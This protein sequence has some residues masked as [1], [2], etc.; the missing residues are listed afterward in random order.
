MSIVLIITALL[1]TAD[2]AASTAAPTDKSRQEEVAQIAPAKA[3]RLTLRVGDK[4]PVEAKLHAEP[5]LRWSNPT[6]GSVYGEVFLWTADRRPAAIAS[7]YRWYDP[8]KDSSVEFVSIA[9]RGVA[10]TEEG[11]THWQTKIPGL[12][13]AD[14]PSAR[15]PAQSGR[16]RL[17]QMRSLAR[18]FS[19][20]LTDKRSGDVVVRKLRLLDQPVYRYDN[21][22]ES[23]LDGGLFAF[24]EGTDPEAWLLLE[25]VA[26]EGGRRW[27]FALARMNIDELRVRRGDAIVKEWPGLRDAWSDRTAP[28]IMFNF[29]PDTLPLAKE[30]RP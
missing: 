2:P 7:I 21:S 5:L 26:G 12:H 24:V 30:P 6:A 23:V 20:E 19:T 4:D 28:Y 27:R 18:E 8:Y 3:K 15:A 17:G 29:D 13:F 14:L 11:V 22:D 10:A 16:A 9:E 1:L 25:A